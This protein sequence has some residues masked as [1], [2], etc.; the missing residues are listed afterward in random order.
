MLNTKEFLSRITKKD[1]ENKKIGVEKKKLGNQIDVGV[2]PQIYKDT[3]IA[4]KTA[5]LKASLTRKSGSVTLH[6]T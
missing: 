2:V 5:D 3:K 4:T 6:P 1:V